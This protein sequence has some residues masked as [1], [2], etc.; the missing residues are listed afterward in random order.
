MV[1][2]VSLSKCGVEMPQT[3]EGK[4][5]HQNMMQEAKEYLKQRGYQVFFRVRLNGGGLLDVLGVKD[6]EKVGI[7][8]Q[9]V[10][11]WTIYVEKIKRYKP[12]L[13]K[14]LLAVPHNAN[15]QLA[16]EGLEILRFKA[17]RTTPHKIT[18]TL[19]DENEKWLRTQNHKKGD[20]SKI[21]NALLQ[22]YFSKNPNWNKPKKE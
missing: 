13:D 3:L 4:E 2:V 7:E 1:G 14:L 19:T 8:C 5:T 22:E 20:M 10:P 6:N 16:P 12:S 21:I 17:N 15:T 9:V 11:N 18:V